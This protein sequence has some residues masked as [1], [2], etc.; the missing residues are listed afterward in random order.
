MKITK[1]KHLELVAAWWENKLEICRFGTKW[2]DSKL[3]PDPLADPDHFRI[4]PQP[5]LRPW[6]PEEV[7]VGAI[8]RFV[9]GRS[10]RS[11]II[12]VG[13]YA[14]AHGID[15]VG[16]TFDVALSRLEHSLDSGKTWKPC[17]V[18]E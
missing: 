16:V 17:G 12:S 18:E 4:R 11:L 15:N 1:E 5:K 7:P 10:Y 3:P 14:F 6:K 9:D 2:E 13:E 8:V